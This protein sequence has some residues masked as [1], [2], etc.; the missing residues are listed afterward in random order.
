MANPKKM[1][2]VELRNPAIRGGWHGGLF[3]TDIDPG[4]ISWEITRAYRR[5]DEVIT[6]TI[7]LSAK[8]QRFTSSTG[9]YFI[10]SN[11]FYMNI[12]FTY[13]EAL[14]FYQNLKEYFEENRS[15]ISGSIELDKL[16]DCFPQ[17]DMKAA[18]EN[19][20]SKR[21]RLT[22]RISMPG[23]PAATTSSSSLSKSTG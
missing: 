14:E 10:L 16:L 3:C 15:R 5:R 20:I 2:D 11:P 7:T 17:N 22:R 9:T 12:R 23:L 6:R 13:E 1:L 4:F 21:P 8:L 18:F 19:G